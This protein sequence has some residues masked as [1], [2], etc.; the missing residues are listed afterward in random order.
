MVLNNESLRKLLA[1]ECGA[2]GW[3]GRRKPGNLVW[4]PECGECAAF[5]RLKI[6]LHDVAPW[7][8]IVL[9]GMMFGAATVSATF[10]TPAP[11]KPAKIVAQL[12]PHVP[13]R[14]IS[15]TPEFLMMAA[16][17]IDATP[18]AEL[19]RIEEAQAVIEVP[20]MVKD[21]AAQPKPKPK[22]K[23]KKKRRKSRAAK[24][25]GAGGIQKPQSDEKKEYRLP[26]LR[27]IEASAR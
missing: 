22:K 16:E 21:E 5:Q 1:V 11:A 25:G 19:P 7:A 23:A 2:C 24:P 17:V 26:W 20:E 4:C 13:A 10:P 9:G 27:A 12:T 18:A 14:I 8:A 15:A 6:A 3:K